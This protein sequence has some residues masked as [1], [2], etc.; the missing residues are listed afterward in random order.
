MQTDR[1]VP[2][3]ARKA[4]SLYQQRRFG[5]LA[6]VS[7][8]MA[9]FPFGSVTPYS[10][11][12]LG[13]ALFLFSGLAQHT[14]N[15]LE[16]PRCSL[17]VY[18]AEAEQNPLDSARMNVLGEVRP[19]PEDEWE[20][21]RELYLRDHPDSEQWIGF[22]DFGLYRLEPADVYIVGGFGEAG[23]VSRADFAAAGEL[24]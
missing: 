15:I 11:D 10:V 12:S 9:G 8:K 7:K 21:A 23:W 14:R 3:R 17:M 16:D 1:L 2:A 22:G 19:V 18:E 6:T 13:R 24:G 5:V 20:A 4:R